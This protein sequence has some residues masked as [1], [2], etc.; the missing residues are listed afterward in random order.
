M[1]DTIKTKINNIP[2]IILSSSAVPRDIKLIEL[3]G[4]NVVV[5]N[6]RS[7]DTNFIDIQYRTEP[8][9]ISSLGVAVDLNATVKM[10]VNN[11]QTVQLEPGATTA[12]KYPAAISGNT[13]NILPIQSNDT[14]YV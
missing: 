11:I 12:K 13:V 8:P 14:N 5:K 9:C 2:N 10:K 1:K 4:N 7:G 6:L 3:D